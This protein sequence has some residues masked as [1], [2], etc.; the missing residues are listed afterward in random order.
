M[1]VSKGHI[2]PRIC[3]TSRIGRIDIGGGGGRIRI[4]MSS[5]SNSSNQS[6]LCLVVRHLSL[7]GKEAL[8]NLPVGQ[9]RAETLAITFDAHYTDFMDS[10]AALPGEA[11]LLALQE[12]DSALNAISSPD[13]AELWTDASFANDPLWDDIRLL[14]RNVLAKFDW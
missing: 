8:T 2:E 4:I 6:S 1:L 7:P 13:T 9:H 10:M 3:T 12:L 11:Q 14:A 5:Q